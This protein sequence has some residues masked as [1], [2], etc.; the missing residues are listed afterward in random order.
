[1]MGRVPLGGAI[2]PSW[3]LRGVPL[4]GCGE[5]IPPQTFVRM[6]PDNSTHRCLPLQVS[7]F[8]FYARL[9]RHLDTQICQSFERMVE[10]QFVYH[11]CPGG[12]PVPEREDCGNV[13]GALRCDCDAPPKLLTTGCRHKECPVC[14]PRW[15]AR[16]VR[17]ALRVIMG[18]VL[19]ATFKYQLRY[20]YPRHIVIS[21][22][23]GM[24]N[25]P[26]GA[27]HESKIEMMKRYVKY[28]TKEQAKLGLKGAVAI[29]HCYRL[30]RAEGD[31]VRDADSRGNRYRA[32]LDRCRVDQYDGVD[33]DDYLLFSPHRHLLAVGSIPDSAAYYLSTG[34]VVRIIRTKTAQRDSET[35][36]RRLN[37]LLSHAW[38][39]GAG[40][41]VRYFGVYKT[42][43][44]YEL[45]DKV[46][47]V[48]S[49]CEECGEPG[50]LPSGVEGISENDNGW[51]SGI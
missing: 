36:S 21:P 23:D 14:W 46:K 12:G 10:P 38:V 35:V 24:F 40:N 15:S 47:S 16:S 34:C 3:G 17:N 33:D 5:G 39:H 31:L 22:P 43:Q 48:A 49:V 7:M 32:A 20:R 26:F 25:L 42:H 30:C 6:Y 29:D 37:Y 8:E 2:A 4:V 13:L 19:N 45:V 18:H 1:M 41:T 44:H 28:I 27:S 11:L 50:I 9:D 51:L